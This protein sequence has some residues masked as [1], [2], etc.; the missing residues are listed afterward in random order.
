M[1]PRAKIWGNDT[2]S[3]SMVMFWYL[4]EDF[5]LSAS[6]GEHGYLLCARGRKPWLMQHLRVSNLPSHPLSSCSDIAFQTIDLAWIIAV[7]LCWLWMGWR[8]GQGVKVG[9][10]FGVSIGCMCMVKADWAGYQVV[11]NGYNNQSK[12]RIWSDQRKTTIQSSLTVR[13]EIL[14]WLIDW[15]NNYSD[16]QQST[17][18]S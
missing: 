1:L 15:F 8:K 3:C 5:H 14:S 16:A 12:S 17:S 11:L 10:P 4:V 7:L 13:K 2:R 18:L 9:Q 6:S